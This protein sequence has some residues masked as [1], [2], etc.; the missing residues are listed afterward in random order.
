MHNQQQQKLNKIYVPIE[1]SCSAVAT[2]YILAYPWYTLYFWL[3]EVLKTAFDLHASQLVAFMRNTFQWDPPEEFLAEKLALCFY[4]Q[5]MPAVLRLLCLF[6]TLY[7]LLI[8]LGI[9]LLPL[10][11]FW[12]RASIQVHYMPVLVLFFLVVVPLSMTGGYGYARLRLP[13]EGVMVV[14]SLMSWSLLV[15]HHW[16]RLYTKQ[17]KN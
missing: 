8:W 14:L 13:V 10:L 17:S 3:Q 11:L 12:F 16:Q 2:P 9:S 5:S 7:L 15:H 1:L 6:D 4:K